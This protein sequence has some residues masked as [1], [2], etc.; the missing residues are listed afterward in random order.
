M[1][2][3]GRHTLP[4]APESLRGFNVLGDHGREGEFHDTVDPGQTSLSR[5]RHT[6]GHGPFGGRHALKHFWCRFTTIAKR[7]HTFV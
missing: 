7:V 3:L 5:F 6:Q 2:H 4:K 1:T